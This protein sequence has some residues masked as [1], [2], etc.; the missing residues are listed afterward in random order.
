MA[1]VRLPKQHGCSTSCR[2]SNVTNFSSVKEMQG[3]IVLLTSQQSQLGKLTFG[4]H[5]GCACVERNYIWRQASGFRNITMH[6][7]R[8][9]WTDRQTNKQTNKQTSVSKKYPQKYCDLFKKPEK[10]VSHAVCRR[11]DNIKMNFEK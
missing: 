6:L 2:S 9:I 10:N 1:P 5:H 3:L 4:K 11:E 7:L 8:L